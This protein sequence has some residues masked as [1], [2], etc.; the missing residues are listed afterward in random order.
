[1]AGAEGSALARC[2]ESPQEGSSPAEALRD[3]EGSA[4]AEALRGGRARELSLQGLSLSD[5]DLRGAD[6]AGVDLRGVDLHG[7]DLRDAQLVKADLRGAILQAADLSGA[8]LLGADLQGAL[9]DHAV[10]VRAG[11]GHSDLRRVNLSGA[12]LTGA[13]L[14]GCRLQGALL[15]GTTLV[16]ATLIEA[17]LSGADFT[18]AN[19]RHAALSG[20]KIDGAI[21]TNAS[22]RE[23]RLA[24]VSGYASASWIGVD[25][26]AADFNGAWLLRRHV[27]DENYIS[28]LRS[29]GQHGELLYWLWWATSDCGRSLARWG[30]WIGVLSL[31][32]AGL[33]SMIGMDFGD[34]PTPIVA[35]YFS[36]VTLTSLGYGDI[37][38]HTTLGQLT[39]ITEVL[40]G[41]IMLGG[42]ISIFANKVARR[43]D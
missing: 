8:E 33:Y 36:V 11:L 3:L 14:T 19:L 29:Q 42:L 5:L 4:L 17:D 9:L 34:N 24:R 27:L 31:S 22:L 28:E 12:D 37:T 13:T 35:L 2:V 20:A 7:A 30:M 18:N 1:M 6:L 32:F 23:A 43:A 25:L 40:M 16:D 41:Y 38:P 10:A 39:A 15:H 21:F 26:R